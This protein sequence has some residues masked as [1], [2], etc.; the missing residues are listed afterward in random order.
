MEPMTRP[1]TP[2]RRSWRP[3]GAALAL[4]LTACGG[5][6]NEGPR[7][8]G[9]RKG[10]TITF[11]T[12]QEQINHLDP[13]RNYAGEDLAFASGYLHRTLNAYAFS[14]DGEEATQ[15]VPDLATD[16]GTPN[17]DATSWT[18]TLKEGL[19]WETR[20]WSA[21]GAGSRSSSRNPSAT[22]TT[23]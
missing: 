19:T 10:G 23:R 15:L 13:Q 2:Y 11:L 12:L 4:V 9:A 17:E 21:T 6:D 20:R 3:V 18:W 5:S 16:T 22:S 8:S 7:E 1:Q 14:A